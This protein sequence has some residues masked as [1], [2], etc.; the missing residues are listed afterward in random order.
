MNGLTIMIDELGLVKLTN[1]KTRRRDV[2]KLIKRSFVNEILL[3]GC[4][5]I[6]L[7]PFFPSS[8]WST[9]LINHICDA[10]HTKL[11]G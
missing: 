8:Y 9:K 7:H 6:C 11:E 2:N 5:L 1:R 4:L 3:I 10:V